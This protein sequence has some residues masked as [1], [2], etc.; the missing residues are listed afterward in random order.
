MLAAVETESKGRAEVTRPWA[1][2]L[3]RR[4][5]KAGITTP[6]QVFGLAW[7]GAMTAPRLAGLLAHLPEGLSEI[8][9]H[10]AKAGGFP[11]A[12]PGYRYAEELAALTDPAVITAAG[13][14]GIRRG[15]FADFMPTSPSPPKGSAEGDKRQGTGAALGSEGAVFAGPS[16]AGRKS[17]VATR[18]QPSDSGQEVA[19]AGRAG[20]LREAKAAEGGAGGERADRGWRGSGSRKADR[21][22]RCARP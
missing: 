1:R 4:L 14:T 11:G 20:M 6:D 2:L 22:C 13:S 9:L 5:G 17:S 19:H 15:G 8:Y 12:A 10:P 18:V 16:R 21:R 3:R 7:S